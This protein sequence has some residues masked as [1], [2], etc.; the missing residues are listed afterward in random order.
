MSI[1]ERG[2][3]RCLDVTLAVVSV[4]VLCP[5]LLIVAL[6]IWAEDGGSVI[7]RQRR[8]G[9][10]RREFKLLKFRSMHENVGDVPSSEAGAL[11][12]TRI[13]RFLR[14][15]NLDELPQLANI[16]RGE[17]SLVGPRPALPTQASLIESRIH[18]GAFVIRPGLTGL[19][20]VSSYDGM[21]ITEKAARDAEYARTVSLRG[22]L[23]IMFRTIGYL[24]RPPPVY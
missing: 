24:F 14:R 18:L 4:I 20:Q 17:M 2:G 8:V 23:Q 12:V 15:T 21:P 22:D 9:R 16:I 5:L 13:G 7:F 1:Y 6:L 10:N 3:K 19:A 11:P